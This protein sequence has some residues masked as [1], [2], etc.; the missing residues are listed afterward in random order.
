VILVNLVLVHPDHGLRTG[1]DAGLGARGGLLDA[2]LR[3]AVADGLG[4]AAVFV[5]LFDMGACA[6]R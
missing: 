6:L 5:H 3:D 4:H 1:V 2:Q